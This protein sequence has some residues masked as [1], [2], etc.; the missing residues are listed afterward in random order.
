M[1]TIVVTWMDGLT[2]VYENASTNVLNGVLH[3]YL[4]AVTGSGAKITTGAWH[5][6]IS[7]IRAWGPEK[8]AGDHGILLPPDNVEAS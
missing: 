6:P 7:N 5:H 3:V 1:D 2:G 4:H 8:W